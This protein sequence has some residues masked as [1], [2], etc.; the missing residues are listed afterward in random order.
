MEQTKAVNENHIQF[1]AQT[2]RQ[3]LNENLEMGLDKK[4]N[5]LQSHFSSE[6]GAQSA[7]DS[8]QDTLNDIKQCFMDS[9]F[10]GASDKEMQIFSDMAG[11][12]FF[13][14]T[15][16]EIISSII[17]YNEGNAQKI[18]AMLTK[19]IADREE[20]LDLAQQSIDK[21]IRMGLV[22]AE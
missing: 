12:K 22:K 8:V 9:Y 4:I 20:F 10:N 17:E 15:A 19:Y 1:Y 21:L 6:A 11:G 5:A 2:I 14:D 3:L 13:G 18:S 7:A 16:W